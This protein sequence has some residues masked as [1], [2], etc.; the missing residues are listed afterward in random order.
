MYDDGDYE[1]NVPRSRIKVEESSSSTN[2]TSTTTPI[3]KVGTKAEGKDVNGKWWKMTPHDAN[4]LVVELSERKQI[5][6]QMS[7]PSEHIVF[8]DQVA[9]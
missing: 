3:V 5:T 7:S 8:A 1:E 2:K 6:A 9:E 4:R